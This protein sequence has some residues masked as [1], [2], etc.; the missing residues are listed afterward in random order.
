MGDYISSN[1][2]SP[3]RWGGLI[4]DGYRMRFLRINVEAQ[5]KK[6]LQLSSTAGSQDQTLSICVGK[7]G[8]LSF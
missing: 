2:S 5:A 1:G 4:S 6:S 3:V 8:S 7:V